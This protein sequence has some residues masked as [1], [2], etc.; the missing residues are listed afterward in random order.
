MVSISASGTFA[1][2]GAMLPSDGTV[3]GVPHGAAPL[4]VITPSFV[5][6]A[7]GQRT[8]IAGQHNT[9]TLTLSP[10]VDLAASDLSAITVSG[11]APEA[12]AAASPM[13][14]RALTPGVNS[15]GLVS[16]APPPAIMVNPKP[17]PQNLNPK[18]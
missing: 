3:L 1:A 5:E 15:L 11:L 16:P 7:A 2:S 9:I 18:P 17:Q 8:P 13:L 14:F 12:F 10:N 6:R 4:L